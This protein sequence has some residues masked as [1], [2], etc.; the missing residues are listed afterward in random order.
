LVEGLYDHHVVDI[1][2]EKSKSKQSQTD[3]AQRL[4]KEAVEKV[5]ATTQRLL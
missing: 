3:R 5:V 4:V 1:L 2:R